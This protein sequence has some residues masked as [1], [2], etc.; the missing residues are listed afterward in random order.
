[1]DDDVGSVGSHMTSCVEFVWCVSMKEEH[2]M[3]RFADTK[4]SWYTC[5]DLLD[6]RTTLHKPY[7]NLQ[8]VGIIWTNNTNIYS[9]FHFLSALQVSFLKELQT[10]SEAAGSAAVDQKVACDSR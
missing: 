10:E 3:N 5:Q 9:L 4:D 1:M 6:T 2:A 7:S 8:V